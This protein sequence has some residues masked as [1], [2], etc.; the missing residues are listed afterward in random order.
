MPRIAAKL[1]AGLIGTTCL[2]AMAGGALA[3]S[4]D[5]NQPMDIDANSS[6]CSIG[7]NSPCIFSGNVHIVQGSLDIRAAKADVRRAGGDIQ[8][9]LI[10]GS[11]AR[12]SQG[13]DNGGTMTASASNV[14]YDMPRETVIFT[15]NVRIEQAGRGAMSGPRIVYNMQTGQVQGGG[16]ESGGQIRT[17]ILP[18]GAQDN[19]QGDN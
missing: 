3:K 13:L 19:Q 17:R 1:L 5:R 16:G 7:D 4:S 11:P 12:L 6:N 18:R 10:S 15:G 2:L 9:V 14:E 8:R